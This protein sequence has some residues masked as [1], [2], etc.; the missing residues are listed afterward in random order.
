MSKFGIAIISF[1]VFLGVSA[2]VGYRYIIFEQNCFG[3]LKRAADSNKITRATKELEIA[4]NYLEDNKLTS[5]YTSIIYRTPDEDIE[6]W[7]ENL[8]DS[9]DNLK[10]IDISTMS[11]LEESNVLM[12]LRETIL[13]DADGTTAITCPDGLSRYPHNALYAIIFWVPLFLS[14]IFFFAGGVRR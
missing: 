4:I 1:I 2:N 9:L 11:Q 12:K 3:H 13:D 5:G 7:Y 10:K 6:F 8:K 14:C